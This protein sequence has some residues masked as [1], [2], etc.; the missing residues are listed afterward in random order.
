MVRPRCK[1]ASCGYSKRLG[2]CDPPAGGEAT[3]TGS[4][5]AVCAAFAMTEI[6]KAGFYRVAPHADSPMCRGGVDPES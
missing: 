1:G 4:L 5:P 6:T 2:H 3:Q